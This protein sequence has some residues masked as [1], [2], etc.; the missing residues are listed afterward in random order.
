ML[1]LRAILCLLTVVLA[2]SAIF[3][4]PGSVFLAYQQV[5]GFEVKYVSINLNDPDVVITTAVA[6]RFPSGLEPWETFLARLHPDVAINGSYF[7]PHSCMPVGDIAVSGTLVYAGVVGT[8]LCIT[9]E[10]QV[11]MRPGPFQVKPDWRGFRTVL[12]AGPRLLTRGEVTVNARAEGFRDPAVLGSAA[13]SAV[14]WRPDGVLILLTVHAPISLR[15]LAYVCRHLGAV[16]AMALDGGSS[17]GLYADGRTLT[18]PARS[19]SN[20]LVVYSSQARFR[21]FAGRVLPPG[22]SQ[23]ASLL[24][25]SPADFRLPLPSPLQANAALPIVRITRPDASR[26]V[27]GTVPIT[28]EVQQGHQVTFTTLRINGVM[29]ALGNIWPLQYE[30]DSTK[31]QDGR[32]TIEVTAWTGDQSAVASDMRVVEV[33][34]GKELARR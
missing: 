14:A 28:I 1:S 18:R 9:P 19:L 7:C 12:C 16:E 17:S 30:W 26:P 22:L 15:N 4:A 3:A 34:N 21:Q 33:R 23:L 29:R 6:T 32:Q 11:V 8:A 24:P 25:T 31:E 10:N 27:Q 2:G 20:I 13:R 5:N